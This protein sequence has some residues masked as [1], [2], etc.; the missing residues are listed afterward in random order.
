MK[1]NHKI[2]IDMLEFLKTG[3][4]DYLE[5]G[6]TQEWM[7]NNF[8]DPDFMSEQ[9]SLTY[10]NDIW[11]YGKVELHFFDGKLLTIWSDH[12]QDRYYQG[13]KF[14]LGEHITV[15]PWIFRHP[16]KLTLDYVMRKFVKV[17][18]D[19][20]KRTTPYS[21]DLVLK[22]GVKLLFQ[23]PNDSKHR[24]PNRYLMT[25]FAFSG[26]PENP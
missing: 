23:N 7:L 12:F 22:S 6:Q 13:K 16:K 3:K 14:N 2:I 25:A 4:F 17:G 5:I 8:P 26:Q 10:G 24:N 21:I 9:G 1:F 15:K 11:M 18:I 19:F 20:D